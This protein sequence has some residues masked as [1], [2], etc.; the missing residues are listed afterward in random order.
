M[1]SDL[2]Q[3][4]R[5]YL[6]KGHKHVRRS[7]LD[8]ERTQ[9]LSR[10]ELEAIQLNKIQ[11][12]VSYAYEHVPFYREKYRRED[13]RPQ[14]IRSF[15]DFQSLP[16]LTRDDVKSRR[17]DL[18]SSGFRG[19]TFE[20]S[21]SGSTGQPIRFLMEKPTAYW[22]YAAEAR[23]RAWYGIY[24]GDKMARFLSPSSPRDAWRFH[25]AN[26]LKRY[27]WLDSQG[28]EEKALKAFAE[29]LMKWHPVVFRAYPSALT[30]FAKYLRECGNTSIKPKL[31]ETTGEKMTPPQ[32]R[33]FAD[34]FEAAI[35]DH[36]SSLEIYSIGY[37]CPRGN[38]HVFEDR[39]LE[40]L[41]DGNVV[42]HG[43]AGE[44]I[45]TSLNQYA[46]PFIRYQNGDAGVLGSE[47]CPCGR[48]MPVLR[49]LQGRTSDVFI[50]PDGKRVHG[51]STSHALWT[52]RE[53]YQYQIYQP[54]IRH[55]EVRLVCKQ[56]VGPDLPEHIRRELQPLF[57]DS[58]DISVKLVED[59]VPSKSGKRLFLISDIKS[60]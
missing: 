10:E 2:Y 22:S 14:D 33:L 44:I 60:D 19:Q 58:V 47:V 4:A 41:R 16:I 20:G 18:I 15:R 13:I 50:R 9:W 34:V 37:E 23:C 5:K 28:L 43:E 29:L 56:N 26:Q 57:G 55:L 40:L 48:S 12:L 11:N 42:P 1:Y 27:R 38:L 7:L 21:T 17:E 3:L 59:I 30:V 53:I 36:Y 35:A 8:L 31:I 49:E 25:P 54:D 52:R 46:M 32:R 45:L 39:Y 51:L 6:F 24:P